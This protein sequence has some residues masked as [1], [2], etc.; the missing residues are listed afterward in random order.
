MKTRRPTS[1]VLA[2]LCSLVDSTLHVVVGCLQ[3]L[4][5][6]FVFLLVELAIRDAM[7]SLFSMS[8]RSS[9]WM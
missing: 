6:V 8:V 2:F 5:L 4:L 9:S 3:L 7:L 1:S